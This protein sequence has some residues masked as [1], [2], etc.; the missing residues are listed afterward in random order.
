MEL[1]QNGKTFT[2]TQYDTHNYVST[3]AMVVQ[4]TSIQVHVLQMNNR[5]FIS[6]VKDI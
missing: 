3:I 1:K 6:A 4:T 2:N 5:R